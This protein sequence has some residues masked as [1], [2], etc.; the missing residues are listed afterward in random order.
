MKI[1]PYDCLSLCYGDT[2]AY[3]GREKGWNED[4]GATTSFYYQV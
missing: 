1:H 3:G 2:W 4:K